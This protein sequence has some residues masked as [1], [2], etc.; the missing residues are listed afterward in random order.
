MPRSLLVR[1]QRELTREV[2][3]HGNDRIFITFSAGATQVEPRETL[4]QSLQRADEAMY[5]S[6]RAGKNCVTVA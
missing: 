1:V 5:R 2:Y 6:K 4:E 3:L